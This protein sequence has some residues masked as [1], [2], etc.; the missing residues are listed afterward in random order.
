MHLQIQ[1]GI[2]LSILVC[3][4]STASNIVDS[5]KQ[6]HVLN[7]SLFRFLRNKKMID[8]CLTSISSTAFMI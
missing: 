5:D 2:V 8:R 3:P 6:P 4:A 7:W 1:E